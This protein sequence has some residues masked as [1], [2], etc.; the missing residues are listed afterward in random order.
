LNAFVAPRVQEILKKAEG[1]PKLHT[2]KTVVCMEGMSFC[3][4]DRS[5]TER[6]RSR[7]F[8]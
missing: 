2:E 3:S 7:L 8:D 6:S 5:T 1:S 4:G